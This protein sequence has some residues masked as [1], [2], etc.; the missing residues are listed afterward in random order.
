VTIGGEKGSIAGTLDWVPLPGSSLPVGLIWASAAVLI[1][2]LAGVF[3]VRRR[4][5]VGEA[6]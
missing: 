2:L 6:W 3:L 1:V 5:P 4:R